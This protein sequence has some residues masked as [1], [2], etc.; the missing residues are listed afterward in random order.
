MTAVSIFVAGRGGFGPPVEFKARQSLS[1][2][3][4]SATP[5]PPRVFSLPPRPKNGGGG[6]IRTRVGFHQTCFQDR[7]LKPLGHPSNVLRANAILTYLKAP[8]KHL[9]RLSLKLNREHATP[10]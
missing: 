3:S 10:G 4:R 9:C 5:A 7:R 6:G 1:R 8:D 2:R